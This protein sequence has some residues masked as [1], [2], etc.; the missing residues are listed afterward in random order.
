[1]G[2]SKVVRLIDGPR[3]ARV[4]QA[5]ESPAGRAARRTTPTSPQQAPGG[6]AR[7]SVK[8]IMTKRVGTIEA[9]S[10]LRVAAR[11]MNRRRIGSLVV[12]RAGGLKGIITEH[13]ILTAV[14][15]GRNPQTTPVR[16]VMSSPIIA[17]HEELEI[18]Q[19]IKL[20]VK[21]SIKKLPILRDDKLV[22]I[23]TFTDF[24]RFG[25]YIQDLLE[26]ALDKASARAR[27][28]FE[29]YMASREPPPLMYG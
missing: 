14:A 24:A 16:A 29:K 26:Q 8:L 9:G 4:A 5:R 13:D 21:H 17:G 22:G 12:M 15:N 10:S 6:D 1:M 28:R 18:K 20:M 19:A 25:P 2:K 23:I 3:A 11:R 7:L 27:A